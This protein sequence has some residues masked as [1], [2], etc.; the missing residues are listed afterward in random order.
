MLESRDWNDQWTLISKDS[1]GVGFRSGR[2]YPVGVLESRPG[3]HCMMDNKEHGRAEAPPGLAV[4][5][6][7]ASVAEDLWQFA[8]FLG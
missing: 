2:G 4:E 5:S 1:S 6:D 3:E 7:G 8:K